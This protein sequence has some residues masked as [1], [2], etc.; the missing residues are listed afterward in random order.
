M[1][2]KDKK[3]FSD[4]VDIWTYELFSQIIPANKEPGS[5]SS[6]AI[7][8]RFDENTTGATENKNE[9]L[10][11]GHEKLGTG[12]SSVPVEPIQKQ[13]TGHEDY[14]QK[15]SPDPKSDDGGEPI[16]SKSS[17]IIT[18]ILLVIIATLLI[19]IGF[20]LGKLTAKNKNNKAEAKTANTTK[21]GQVTDRVDGY[22]DLTLEKNSP[23]TEIINKFGDVYEFI[24]ENYYEPVDAEKL[25][26]GAIEGM[27]NSLDDPYGEYYGPDE[28]SNYTDFISGEFSGP[29]FKGRFKTAGNG[30][31]SIE[32]ISVDEDSAAAQAGIKVKER[33]IQVNGKS[34]VDYDDNEIRQLFTQDGTEVTLKIE[35]EDGAQYDAVCKVEKKIKTTVEKKKLEGNITYVKISQFIRGTADAFVKA[36][37]DEENETTSGIII[38][39]RDNPGGYAD[40]AAKV[41]DVLLG[42]GTVAILK[43]RNDEPAETFQS[44]STEVT[45]PIVLIVN[46]KTASSAEILTMAFKE[47]GKGEIVGVKTYG[48]ALA[49]IMAKYDFDGSGLV[50]SAYRVFSESGKCIDGVGIEPT[51]IVEDDGARLEKAIEV[52]KA[53]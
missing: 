29:G 14:E 41:A 9:F 12:E 42:E 21:G 15:S 52:I 2:S 13:G 22:V 38:D 33:I 17:K 27:V 11:T 53:A 26:E 34:I 51:I 39:L 46:E 25:L 7:Y 8:G 16:I 18:I 1:D 24:N 3:N 37:N 40:E 6:E 36:V 44:D 32:V 20:V 30:E 43:N 35:K 5:D 31:R 10:G 19:M 23:R 47:F 49:Q 48:K 50:L 4:D 45:V 28:M